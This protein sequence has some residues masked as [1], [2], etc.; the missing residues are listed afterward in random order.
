MRWGAL[1]WLFLTAGP[2]LINV[3]APPPRRRSRWPKCCGRGPVPKI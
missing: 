1:H 3:A 2:L